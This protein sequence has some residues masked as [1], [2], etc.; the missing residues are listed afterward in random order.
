MFSATDYSK[1]NLAALIYQLLKKHSAN[2]SDSQVSNNKVLRQ[3]ITKKAMSEAK[4]LIPGASSEEWQSASL[5][6]ASL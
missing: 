3:G 6:L 1:E 5:Y 2:Y 4:E